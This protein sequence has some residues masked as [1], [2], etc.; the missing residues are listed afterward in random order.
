MLKEYIWGDISLGGFD[1]YSKSFKNAYHLKNIKIK[2]G[3]VLQKKSFPKK[4][5]DGITEGYLL[6][7]DICN[8]ECL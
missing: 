8:R 3:S 1:G 5:E 7:V 6:M 2:E 4:T